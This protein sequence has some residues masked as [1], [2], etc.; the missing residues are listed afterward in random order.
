M[1][2]PAVVLLQFFWDGK[3]VPVEINDYKDVAYFPRVGEIISFSGTN[4]SGKKI[5]GKIEHDYAEQDL[6]FTHV[7]KIYCY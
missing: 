2:K 3:H 7:V 1:S 5:V 4:L 6:V